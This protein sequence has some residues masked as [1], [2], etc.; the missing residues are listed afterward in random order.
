MVSQAQPLTCLCS[1]LKPPGATGPAGD[2]V[3]FRAEEASRA[4]QERA[5][6]RQQQMFNQTVLERTQT[7]H[8]AIHRT[9]LSVCKLSM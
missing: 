7:P 5:A 2:P 6:T 8:L 9:A 1:W 4:E 3:M